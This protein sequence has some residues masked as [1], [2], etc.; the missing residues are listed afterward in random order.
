MPL[1]HT[2]TCQERCPPSNVPD[3]TTVHGVGAPLSQAQLTICDFQ[4]R[5][6]LIHAHL[7]HQQPE[8]NSKDGLGLGWVSARATK[9]MWPGMELECLWLDFSGQWRQ[10]LEAQN[11]GPIAF[12]LL[13]SPSLLTPSTPIP[14]TYQGW[15][16]EVFGYAES[17]IWWGKLK[18]EVTEA[19]RWCISTAQLRALWYHQ[20]LGR[21]AM[22]GAEGLR[23]TFGFTDM[24]GKPNELGFCFSLFMENNNILLRSFAPRMVPST[25]GCSMDNINLKNKRTKNPKHQNQG[26]IGAW[27][28][29]CRPHPQGRRGTHRYP[30]VENSRAPHVWF[31]CCHTPFLLSQTKHL[32]MF[33]PRFLIMGR[34][35]N[36]Q[37]IPWARGL[38]K[39]RN[40]RPLPSGGWKGIYD[41]W[42]GKP[43]EECESCKKF[44]FWDLGP[45]SAWEPE[46]LFLWEQKCKTFFFF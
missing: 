39:I 22:N 42:A 16:D 40:W 10:L 46:E 6:N 27:A 37:D 28:D 18:N 41:F 19:M 35:I 13:A 34:S 3:L 14:W 2:L 23:S 33:S 24:K 43:A 17:M 36:C 31:L 15:V 1:F 29:P 21:Q 5:L 4:L 7:A 9:A 8:A 20:T 12:S 45:G 44:I 11:S 38:I 25:P 30:S 26:L 32:P